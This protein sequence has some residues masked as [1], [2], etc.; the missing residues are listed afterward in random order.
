M[1]K[2]TLLLLTMA[3]VALASRVFAQDLIT[4]LI[5]FRTGETVFNMPASD[6]VNLKMI[7]LG[8]GSRIFGANA[9]ITIADDENL[10]LVAR[11]GLCYRPESASWNEGV[12]VNIPVEAIY[13]VGPETLMILKTDN[14]IPISSR[15]SGFVNYEAAVAQ[16]VSNLDGFVI[17][18]LGREGVSD[19]WKVG[20]YRPIPYTNMLVNLCYYGGGI[21][22]LSLGIGLTSN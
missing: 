18:G 7:G 6:S 14:Y 16:N 1:K 19:Y 12:F 13:S 4:D 15:N 9:P 20:Y 11:S 5:A 21:K 22:S 17:G 2:L 8:T 3:L 10:F